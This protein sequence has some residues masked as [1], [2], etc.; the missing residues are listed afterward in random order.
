ML[1]NLLILLNSAAA[2]GV[3]PQLGDLGKQYKIR[4]RSASKMPGTEGG[5]KKG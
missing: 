1:E 3:G 2:I 5:I 4:Q